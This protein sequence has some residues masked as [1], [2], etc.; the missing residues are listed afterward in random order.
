MNR[1]NLKPAKRKKNILF[2]HFRKFW[3]MFL[4][5][6]T[7]LNVYSQKKYF[8][9]FFC[10][11]FNEAAFF[12]SGTVLLGISVVAIRACVFLFFVFNCSP[13]LLPQRLVFCLFFSK[14]F[15]L[16]WFLFFFSLSPTWS[17]KSHCLSC[18]KISLLL[19][20]L[21]SPALDLICVLFFSCSK[22]LQNFFFFFSKKEW[23]E[24]GSFFYLVISRVFMLGGFGNWNERVF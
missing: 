4:W 7:P 14:L 9:P 13:A 5:R 17:M 16:A 11:N 10:C 23:D 12:S 20:F 1:K 15:S 8:L 22:L 6:K 24:E 2:A 3:I 18:A 19:F 21:S